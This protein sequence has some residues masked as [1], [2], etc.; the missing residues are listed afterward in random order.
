MSRRNAV[1]KFTAMALS[2]IMV[3]GMMPVSALAEEDVFPLG[4]SGG[5]TAFGVMGPDIMTAAEGGSSA[6]A[7][8]GASIFL[9][10]GT[11]DPEGIEGLGTEEAPLRI[12]TEVQLAA[13]AWSVNHNSLP[14]SLPECPYLIL[15]HDLDLSDYNGE[16]SYG[17]GWVPIGGYYNEEEE[18]YAFTGTFD[19]NQKTIR[20]L[21]VENDDHRYVGLFGYI[22]GGTVKNLTVE[23]GDVTGYAAT[24]GIVG[25]LYLGQIENCV[26][27]GSVTGENGTGGI[28]GEFGDARIKDCENN[29][30]ITGGSGTGGIVGSAGSYEEDSGIE[31]CTNTGEVIGSAGY[32]GGIAGSTRNI[33]V[34]DCVN[35]G[36]I[37][38]GTGVNTGGV[39]GDI[40][41]GSIQNCVNGGPVS[42]I[43]NNVGGVAGFLWASTIQNCVNYADVSSTANSIGGVAGFAKDGSTVINCLTTGN[44]EGEVNIPEP[45]G[46]GGVVG[47]LRKDSD[48]RNT[49]SGC[50]ALGQTV[51]K[52]GEMG[53]VARIACA[54][55][56]G[57]HTVSDN[58]AWGGMQLFWKD[59]LISEEGYRWL[60]DGENADIAT[61]YLLWTTGVL[62]ESW[63]DT[64][65]WT[66]AEGKLPVLTGLPHQSDAFPSHISGIAGVTVSPGSAD[67]QKGA[68]KTFTA[69]V[70]GIGAIDD[71]VTWSVDGAARAGTSVDAAGMLTVAAD[72]TAKTLVVTATAV[73]DS[74]KKGT[75]GVTVTTGM[76]DSTGDSGPPSAGSSFP[77]APAAAP[78]WLEQSGTPTPIAQAK[79]EAH[80]Y[81]LTRAS[82]RYG[83][84]A[85]AWAS[86]SGYQYWHDTMDGNAVQLRVYVKNPAAVTA[87]LLVS[88]YVRGA[89]VQ[90]TTALFEKYFSNKVST[91]HLDQTGDW[92]QPVA[93]AARVDLSG[94]DVS[95]LMLYSYDKATNTYRRI[96]KPA[97][98]IDKNGYLHFTTPYA[99]DIII[100]EGPLALQKGGAE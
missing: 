7:A 20:G 6:F 89:E 74:S 2:A 43:A 40:I 18:S 26:F 52:A 98:W 81:A 90:G 44:V 85:S 22:V 9:P 57:D 61:L 23:D 38:G 87:D 28:V 59:E 11:E 50:V 37:Q 17:T 68:T 76:S 21:Y 16:N 30:S 55:D 62:A 3:A 5:V 65:V 75:A 46:V 66:L 12:E 39:V 84:R 60:Q 78:E 33:S 32:T 67:V 4:T 48:S 96:E 14:V 63:N 82:S 73:G 19:G 71:T 72:E 42:G 77:A 10:N 95:K 100:S 69:T 93:L 86:F 27:S 79:E 45:G 1:R 70:T 34:D 13:L 49:L 91:V 51:I 53:N 94:M 56:V 83:V 88:G 35:I 80:G 36:A 54:D 29:G 47:M 64:G 25:C 99:G 15:V 97:Y 24:G 41:E 8:R 31:S 58:F 92:G